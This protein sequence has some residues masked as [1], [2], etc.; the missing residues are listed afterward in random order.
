[1]CLNLHLYDNLS[2]ILYYNIERKSGV[3]SS[4]K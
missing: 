2:R 1:M 4:E 3:H